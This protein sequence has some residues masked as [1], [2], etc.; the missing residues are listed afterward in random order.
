MKS[1]SLNL[2][3]L[4]FTGPGVKPA[5]VTFASGLNIIWGASD[6]GKSF[7]LASL[8]FMLGASSPLPDIPE[9]VGYDRIFLTLS[10]SDGSL[11]T[12][13]RSTAG[14]DFLLREGDQTDEASITDGKVLV[15]KHHPTKDNVSTFLLDQI[16]L[17]NK[18]IKRKGDGTTSVFSMPYLRHLC[19]VSENEIQKVSSPILTGQFTEAT[20]EMSAFKLLLTGVDDSAVVKTTAKS[21]AS[22][23][24]AKIEIISDLLTEYQGRFRDQSGELPDGNELDEQ[25]GKVEATIASEQE[26]LEFSETEYSE[27]SGRRL[28]LRQTI[29]KTGDRLSEIQEMLERFSLLRKHYISDIDRLEGV[30]EA[31]SLV[32]AISAGPCPLCGAD[33]SYPHGDVM[34]DSDLG[35]VVLAAESEKKKIEKL[36][37]ELDDLVQ[38]LNLEKH[39]V[40]RVIP[41][42]REEL[43]ELDS[44]ISERVPALSEQRLSYRSLI[45]KRS[46][47]QSLRNLWQEI[48]ALSQ[49]K[50]DLEATEDS[51][52][53]E[54]STT[55]DLSESVLD[56]FS[57]VMRQVLQS[58]RFPGADRIHFDSS[59]RKKDFVINGK[60]RGSR[61]KGMRAITHAG[62]TVSLMDFVFGKGLPHLGFVVMDSPLLAYREP[63]AGDDEVEK[64]G[65][66]PEFF[67]YLSSRKDQQFIII[68][69]VDPP[70]EFRSS[71]NSIHFSGNSSVG[72]QGFFPFLPSDEDAAV[73]NEQSV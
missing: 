26:K 58:W 68:E 7:I 6:T 62:F 61:G 63:D 27:L 35:T 36:L 13:V 52:A 59:H 43:A 30:R 4:R 72:R 40:Q 11:F 54:N 20:A 53:G 69:N 28:G 64:A 15:E 57:E 41:R 55:A 70:E 49:K 44:R 3:R 22:N 50:S 8:E 38:K 16:G 34:C 25:L 19:I 65:L 66:Q 46:S 14:G 47:V 21:A 17:S 71:S 29:E 31:G 67:K 73:V 33:S 23:A 37:S 18:R 45:E 24:G 56:A 10:R 48:Q 60:P 1:G 51:Q 9:R 39:S 2:R 42:I 12:L 5:E 32:A